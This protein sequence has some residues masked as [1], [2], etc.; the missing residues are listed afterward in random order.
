VPNDEME[1][2]LRARWQSQPGQGEGMPFEDIRREAQKFHNRLRR[3]NIREY[4][5]ASITI[6]IFLLEIRFIPF[7]L[8]IRVALLLFI[9]GLLVFIYQIRKRGSP[10]A[11]PSDL[12]SSCLDFHR[13][14]LERQRDALASFWLWGLWPFLPGAIVLIVSISFAPRGWIAALIVTAF[15]AALFTFFGKLNRRD[16]RKLQREIDE[17]RG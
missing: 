5:A 17:L 7:P 3:R 8:P 6:L 16:A 12:S 9:A 11:L 4:I 15:F 2:D 14:E 13:R 1:N 10:R